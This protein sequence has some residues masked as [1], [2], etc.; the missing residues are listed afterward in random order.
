MGGPARW[1]AAEASGGKPAWL[2]YFSY[3]GSRFRPAKTRASHADEIQYVWE[4][5]GRR[6]PTSMVNA[7]DQEVATLMHACWVAFA[8][9]GAPRC[10][11]MDWPAYKPSSDQLME[12]GAVSGARTHFRKVELDAMQATVLPTLALSK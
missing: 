5:W 10:G 7:K 8:K 6:T 4:Y 9:T 3:I 1:V 12:F 2:Y 11:G